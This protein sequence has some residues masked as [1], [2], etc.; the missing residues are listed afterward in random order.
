MQ[1]KDSLQQRSLHA[2]PPQCSNIQ[3]VA[4]QLSR[5]LRA[6]QDGGHLVSTEQ[7]AELGFDTATEPKQPKAR[8]RSAR[9]PKPAQKPKA[10]GAPLLALS[11]SL[12]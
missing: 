9:K 2:C 10:G 5:Q 4:V 6:V 11:L 7:L 12:S 8:S 3:C 1:C